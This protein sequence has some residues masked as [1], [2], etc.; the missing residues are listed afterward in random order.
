MGEPKENPSQWKRKF[1]KVI[2]MSAS[3]CFH[4]SGQ[5]M[6]LGLVTLSKC[7]QR[8]SRHL[9]YSAGPHWGRVHLITA[10]ISEPVLTGESICVNDGELAFGYISRDSVLQ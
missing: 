9:S 6:S 2:F 7:C 4:H 3:C 1:F 8:P 10:L 5:E